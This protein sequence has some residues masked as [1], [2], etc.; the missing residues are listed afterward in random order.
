M[1]THLKSGIAIATAAAAL[2]SAGLLATSTV[3][4][5]DMGV[6]CTGTNSCKG[7]SECKTAKSECKGQNSCKGM[8]WVSAK[9]AKECTDA[10][11]KVAK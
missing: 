9:S 5:A 1:S 4:A 10:G 6:K 7:T 3:Q 11:G 8:G 2:F